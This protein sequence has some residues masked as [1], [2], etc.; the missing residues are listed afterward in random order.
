MWI[1]NFRLLSEIIYKFTLHSWLNMFELEKEILLP[2]SK[3]DPYEKF[4]VYC[5]KSKM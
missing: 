2:E 1:T 5:V 3:K 4:L